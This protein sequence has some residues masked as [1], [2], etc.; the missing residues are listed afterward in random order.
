M[1]RRLAE[2]KTAPL[3]LTWTC[4]VVHIGPPGLPA[5]VPG[6]DTAAMRDRRVRATG[7]AAAVAALLLSGCAVASSPWS[8]TGARLASSHPPIR[9]NLASP[10]SQPG[11][12]GGG[13]AVFFASGPDLALLVRWT[14]VAGQLAGSLDEVQTDSSAQ[15]GI[16]SVDIGFTGLRDG[17][18]IS[19]TLAQGLGTYTALTGSIRGISLLLTIPQNDG[20][21]VDD[22]LSSSTVDAFNAA[23]TQLAS[24]GQQQAMQTANAQ[25]SAAAEAQAEA[26]AS[27]QAAAQQSLDQQ[28]S[29]ADSA[30]GSDLSPLMRDTLSIPNPKDLYSEGLLEGKHALAAAAHDYRVEEKDAQGCTAANDD[31]TVGA[32]DATVGS[33][34]ADVQAAQATV[35]SNDATEVG[36]AST[37]TSDL[38]QVQTDLAN[39]DAAEQADP[40]STVQVLNSAQN[41]NIAKKQV[42]KIL[43]AIQAASGAADQ[44]MQ[45]YVNEADAIQRNADALYNAACK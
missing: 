19:L 12:Q 29:A 38:Q 26:A 24:A 44:Q 28:L 31:G 4:V 27:Q 21:L 23:V 10:D 7:T 43:T 9:S 40:N 11:G 18:H 5:A 42:D 17:A 2:L 14:D 41:V 16:S 36:A 3:E 20:Q 13:D 34:N 39:L 35:Q 33:D 15:S 6:P 32:D 8:S 1:C 37:V 45:K 22:T 30:V 25:A